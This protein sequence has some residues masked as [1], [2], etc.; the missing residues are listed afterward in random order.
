MKLGAKYGYKS[1]FKEDA[2][3][4][5][6]TDKWKVAAAIKGGTSKIEGDLK[7]TFDKD[8]T[9]I[10]TTKNIMENYEIITVGSRIPADKSALTWA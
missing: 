5:Q 1:I 10:D 7:V 2:L 9:K 3:R 6:N 4:T 8:Q